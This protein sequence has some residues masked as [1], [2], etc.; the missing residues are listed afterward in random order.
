MPRAQNAHAYVNA[1]FL[2]SVDSKTQQIKNCRICF[3][4]ISTNFVHAWSIEELMKGQVYYDKILLEKIF[5]QL[6]KSLKPNITLREAS[7][8]YRRILAC[9]LLYKCLLEIAP[10]D[11]VKSEYKSGGTLLMRELS[12]GTQTFVTNKKNYPVTQPV[13]KLEGMINLGNIKNWMI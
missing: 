1:A 2:L 4:G 9:G 13:Q 12:S 5:S 10:S 6:P 3:G 11:K 8:E 7:P